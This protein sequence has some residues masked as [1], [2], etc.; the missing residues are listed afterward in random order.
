MSKRER[1]TVARLLARSLVRS[2]GFVRPIFDAIR[3]AKDREA[4]QEAESLLESSGTKFTDDM[5]RKML[6][7]VTRN[8]NFQA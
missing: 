6:E 7:R 8:R 1:V 2:W 5:E 3:Q 4:A